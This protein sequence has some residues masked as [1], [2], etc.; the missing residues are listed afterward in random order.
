MWNIYIYVTSSS[1]P[2]G[3]WFRTP[4]TRVPE[5][6]RPYT[7]QFTFKDSFLAA[8]IYTGL[9]VKTIPCIK[10]IEILKKTLKKTSFVFLDHV[11]TGKHWF[12]MSI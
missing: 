9:I 2:C 3:D 8:R 11:P 12:S 6:V 4:F 1:T 5:F 7:A 10:S